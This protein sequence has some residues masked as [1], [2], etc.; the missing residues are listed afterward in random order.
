MAG[1]A[2]VGY[3]LAALAVF[4]GARLWLPC[5]LPVGLALL[6]CVLNALRFGE[7]APPPDAGARGAG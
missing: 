5:A 6:G 4:E 7:H 1:A 2:L 3:A